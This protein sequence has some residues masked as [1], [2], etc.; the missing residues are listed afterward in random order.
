MLA[1]IGDPAAPAIREDAKQYREDIARAYHWAQARTP[2]VQ[3]ANGT[4]VPADPSFM[5]CFGRVEDFLPAEDADRTWGYSVELGAHHLAATD[6]LD[7]ASQDADWMIDYLED[8]QFLR[9]GWG[10]YPEENNRKD[11]FCFG[12][13][14]KLQ[15]YYCRIAEIHAM[16]DD[17][18]P[19]VR[20]YFNC[21]PDA[22][23]P[24]ESLLLGAFRQSRR[25]EQDARDRLVPLPNPDH[26][27][28]PSAATSCGWPRS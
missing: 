13:F 27:R 11:V 8:V 22:R 17:V 5:D 24:R 18:K 19:F 12:G 7:P 4:W 20:S 26:V 16:R 14:A 25:L 23:E 10:D 1:D 3:L 9:T 28:R 15:P 6:V 21:D 2:V